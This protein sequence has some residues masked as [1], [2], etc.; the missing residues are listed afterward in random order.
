MLGHANKSEDNPFNELVYFRLHWLYALNRILKT[1]L[2][3]YQ[4]IKTPRSIQL[5][6]LVV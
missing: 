3:K 5:T 1:G 4:R 2:G 6:S